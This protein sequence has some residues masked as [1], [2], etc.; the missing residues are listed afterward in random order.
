MQI[1]QLAPPKQ[2][3]HEATS[4][5]YDLERMKQRVANAEKASKRV[6]KGLKDPNDFLRWLDAQ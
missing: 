3:A 1:M 2:K 6:P 5:T 4:F